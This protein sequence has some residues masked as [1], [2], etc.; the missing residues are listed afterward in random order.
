MLHDDDHRKLAQHLDLLHFQEEAPGMVFWHPR[1]LALYRLLEHAARACCDAQGYREVK[2]PQLVRRPIWEASGHWQHFA[3][4]MF[5]LDDQAVEA[6]IKPVSCPGHVQIVNR[7]V[8]SYRELPIRLSELGVVHRDEPSGALHGLLRLRQFT[9][10]DGH[11]FC[12]EEQ[13]A[14]EIDRF[15]RALPAFYAAFGFDR[16]SLAFATRPEQRA[17]DDADWD[18]AEAMLASVLSKLG[19]PHVVQPGEGA[20]Y[21]PKLELSLCDR[22]GR[23]WQCGT[24]QLD[25]VMPQ[26]FDLRY[27]DADGEKKPLVMLHRALYGSLERFLGILLEHHGARLPAW[28]AP[29]QVVVLPVADAHLPWARQVEHALCSSG[30]RAQLDARAESLARRV[31]EAH[32]D[33][34]P[35]VAVVG[36]REVQAGSVTLRA[37]DGQQTLPFERAVELLKQRCALPEFAPQSASAHS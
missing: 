11:V 22:A 33:A 13:A 2:T 5:R 21:G 25:L 28:L 6:G 8:P 9:Q 16:L 1:G 4:G 17:G 18:R 34:V 15:C 24:I 3:A 27:V 26:R 14:S 30:L 31:A 36:A 10:D 23:A 35:F 20:F 29:Q 12:A 32:D 7:R 19:V 37:R